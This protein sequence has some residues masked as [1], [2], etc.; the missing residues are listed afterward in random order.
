MTLPRKVWPVVYVDDFRYR[1]VLPGSSTIPDDWEVLEGSFTTSDEQQLICTSP[2][3]LRYVGE[4][5]GD[6]VF[7]L[8]Q[9]VAYVIRLFGQDD[10]QFEMKCRQN[11]IA[12]HNISLNVDFAT[13]TI[14]VISRTSSIENILV[15]NNYPFRFGPT[16]YYSIEL[17]TIGDQYWV[18]INGTNIANGTLTNTHSNVNHGFDLNIQSIPS[19]GAKFAKFAVHELEEFPDV[20]PN[21]DG[22]NLYILFRDLMKTQVES[23]TTRNWQTFLRARKFWDLQR[24]TGKHNRL[25]EISGYPIEEPLPENWLY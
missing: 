10:L 9:N 25:W 22:S 16:D 3:T 19:E 11:S 7:G 17:W 1:G 18:V 21:Y 23:P 13:G 20:E 2:G 4:S 24:N 14:R 5:F 8:G 15:T 6:I 12:T